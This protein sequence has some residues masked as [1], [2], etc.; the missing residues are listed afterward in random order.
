MRDDRASPTTSS[1]DN[2][3]STE[4]RVPVTLLQT[5]ACSPLATN[6]IAG[7]I[8]DN[9]SSQTYKELPSVGTITVHDPFTGEPTPLHRCR[10]AGAATRASPRWSACG[11]R[12]P[13]CSTTRV[14]HVRPSDPSV[15][16]GWR[17][18]RRHRADAVAGEARPSD[19][20]LGDKVPGL[21]DRT[22]EP[23]YLVIPRGFLPDAAVKLLEPFRA[24]L[25]WLFNA[26][27]DIELGP[28][29]K[30][31]PV[32]LLANL[33]LR[34][35]EAD[36]LERVAHDAKLVELVIQLKRDLSDAARERQR[37]AGARS[38]SPTSSE[39]L[40]ALSKCPDFVVNRGHYFGTDQFA[41]EP[42]L[43]DHDKRDLID[44]LKTLLSTAPM[45][46]PPRGSCRLRLRRRRL[47]RR[48]RHGGRAP[49][50]GRARGAAARG[51]RRSALA[52]GR[53]AG[54]AAENRLPDD[55]D[56]P[57]FHPLRLRERG[58]E[59]GLLR[60]PLRRRRAAAARP[61]VRS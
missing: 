59:L 9:F 22:T 44:F 20:V 55:Y 57:A 61:E 39:P 36:L 56:V 43:S 6:A 17:V 49:G 48:R 10:P 3:L 12:R 8:W 37:R 31:T 24:E 33:E 7:N 46:W 50:R 32:G 47:G 58:D 35:D 27:G 41:E 5:N 34:P 45:P 26:N 16:A 11:R 25:P 15:E 30:G 23:S 38:A 4:L 28:I 29:P 14:G 19:P 54:Q 42:G 40:L 52:R 18:R 53:R 51:G 21:I 13:T 1:T 2:I 60:P